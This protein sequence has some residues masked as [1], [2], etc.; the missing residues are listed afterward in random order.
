MRGTFDVELVNDIW[1][2]GHGD[3]CYYSDD[4]NKWAA[5]YNN[6]YFDDELDYGELMGYCRV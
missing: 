3:G 6:Y 5:V 1:L 4:G 2:T